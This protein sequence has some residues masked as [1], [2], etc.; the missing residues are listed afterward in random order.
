MRVERGD[1]SRRKGD[2]G[3]TAAIERGERL[4]TIF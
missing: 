2:Y 3:A 1:T 4:A